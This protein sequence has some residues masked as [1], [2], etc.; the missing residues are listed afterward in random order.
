MNEAL[1]IETL[2][3]VGASAL[4]VA[5]LSRVGLPAML[6]YLF[7]GVLVG[8]LGLGAVAPSDGPRFLAELGLILLMFMVG[9]DFSWAEIWAA[10]RAVF[11]AGTLQV[12]LSMT[13][14]AL[15]AHAFDMPWPAAVLA[16]GAAAMCSTGIALKQLQEQREFARTHGRIA[17]GILLFQDLA[18]LPFLVVIDSG[19]AA[20]SI[21]FVTAVKQLMV[22]TLSLG[23]LLWLGRPVLRIALEWIRQRQSVD[24]FLLV[25]LL[26]ALGAAYL[27]KQLGAAPMI[28]AFLAGVAV[29]ESDLSHRVSEQLRPF[30]DMLLGLFFVTVGMQI[31]PKTVAASPLQ[32]L[33]WLALFVLAKPVLTFAAT[34]AAG[35]DRMNAGR[36]GTVLAHASELTLLIITQAMS[37]ALLPAGPGQ[38]MLVAAALSMGLAPVVIQHNRGIVIRTFRLLKRFTPVRPR[39]VAR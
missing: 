17:T 4:A 28:G 2:T 36:A 9:L 20:G 21:V 12:A 37:A 35:Y 26:L 19:S 16:G 6:G 27:A 13:C 22:A 18:T 38:A 25:A 14:A 10:R 39:S 29:G 32:T 3:L 24:L 1:L 31:D 34:R 7:A 5:L 30:R 11:F 23:G 33:L 8:P 15:V